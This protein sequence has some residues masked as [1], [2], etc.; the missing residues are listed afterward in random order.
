MNTKFLITISVIITLFA[1]NATK[2]VEITKNGNTVNKSFEGKIFFDFSMKDKTGEMPAEMTNMMFGDRQTYTVKKGMYK[3]E[4][5]GQ[6]EMTQ[7]YPGEDSLFMHMAGIEGLLWNEANLNTEELKDFEIEENAAKILDIN[8]HLI[9]MNTSDG[10]YK[11]YYN[12]DYPINPADYAKHDFAFWKFYVEKAKAQPL[13][14]VVDTDEIY[15]EATATEIKAMKIDDSEFALPNMPR[16][17][18]PEP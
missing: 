14:I 15:M 8:C 2:K 10:V 6:M 13:K 11:Y 17:K 5:N 7:I 9:T 18:N 12:L 4:F 3:S 1:C 16:V